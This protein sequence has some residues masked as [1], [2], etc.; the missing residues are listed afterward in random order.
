[1]LYRLSIVNTKTHENANKIE[2][3]VSVIMRVD[4]RHTEHCRDKVATFETAGIK[5]Y[6]IVLF[7]IS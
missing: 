4:G 2:L 1:M 3:L 5:R 6:R 7:F